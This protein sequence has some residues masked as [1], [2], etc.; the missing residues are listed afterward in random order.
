MG[1]RHR[2]S[3]CRAKKFGTYSLAII[4][5]LVWIL[6]W[7]FILGHQSGNFERSLWMEEDGLEREKK[8]VRR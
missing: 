7:H 3:L 6:V 4:F 1:A 5:I 8:E 2:G